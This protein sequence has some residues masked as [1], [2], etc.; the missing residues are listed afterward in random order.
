MKVTE[1]PSLKTLN[2][3]GVEAFAG[4]MLTLETEEDLLSL[5]PFKTDRDLLLGGGS[6]ILFASNIP[7]TVFRNCIHG[8]EVVKSDDDHVWVEAG[9][10]EIWHE[11]V[12]W[13]LQ[14]G[15][16]GLENLS[17]IP[18]FAGAAPIQ[19]IGAYGVEISSVLESVTAWD[20]ESHQW[21]LFSHDQCQLAYRD[22]IFKSGTPDRYLVTS[23]RLKLDRRFSPRLDYSGLREELSHKGIN[24]PMAGQVSD[25]VIRLRQRKLPDPGITGNAGSFFKNPVLTRQEVSSLQEQNP[26]IPCWPQADDKLKISAAWLIEQCGFKGH[27]H[28]GAGVSDRHALVLVNHGN[29]SGREIL[30]LATRIQSAVYGKFGVTLQPE[31]KVVNFPA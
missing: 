25:A 11:L 26:E 18:G 4:L 29:A 22:S 27:R 21:A 17:L 14:Q 28:G 24:Q 12:L 6:N 31:P 9:A 5:P 1:R 20:L 13:T 19:N 8:K 23:I 3:F 10:G 7:G 16:S 30:A 15:F 2:T